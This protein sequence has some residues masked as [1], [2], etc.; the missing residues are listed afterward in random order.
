MHLKRLYDLLNRLSSKVGGPRRLAD[1]DSRT[2]WPQR[3]VYFF[4]EP[5][6]MRPSG[7]PR[8]VR[9]GTHAVSA[10]SQST[11][12]G[13]LKQHRGNGK[14]GEAPGTGN[15]R[16]SIFRRHVGTAL[17]RAGR[18]PPLSSWGDGSSASHEVTVLE[19][20]LEQAVSTYVGQMPFLWLDAD[21]EPSAQSVRGY[22][23]RNSIGLL[24]HAVSIEPPS[25]GW[26]GRHAADERIRKSGLWNVNFV[27]DAYDPGFLD[28]FERLVE[29]TWSAPARA[30]VSP[31]QPNHA[32]AG[33][34]QELADL[35]PPVLALISC[36]KKKATMPCAASELYR[37]STFFRLAFETA[38]RV[39]K[40]TRILSA[41]QGLVRPDEVVA[42]YEQSLVGA[43]RDERRRWA[44]RVYPQLR[45]C[46]EYL[47]AKTVVWFAGESY[48][49][50][51]LPM[52]EADGKRCVV[53]MEGLAQGEQLHWLSTGDA[54]THPRQSLPSRAPALP[55][56]AA[57]NAAPS[58]TPNTQDFRL[59]LQEIKDKAA[60]E[61]RSS[62]V[63]T[64]GALHRIVGGYPG[65]HHRMPMCCQAMRA[66]MQRG[67]AIVAQPPKGNG[68]SLEIA[69]SLSPRS[70][71][72]NGPA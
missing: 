67:D 44:E 72:V 38:G 14:P 53:P 26:L 36:T 9:V 4:F 60:N 16:G 51:L 31:V 8:V 6:E 45:A 20:P 10:G 58:T 29:G 23:E 64:A 30:T 42:P 17:L 49:M 59:A 11:L 40:T 47:A 39:A 33:V 21:D 50:D 57:S 48:R 34:P 5:G 15:H 54:P 52:V 61:G 22:I 1:C 63:V 25:A 55:R 37:P 18:H 69:Y 7:S 24:S 68:A 71:G 66:A 41:K 35:K 28:V 43:S 65:P 3:G 32:G 12:W 13:R 56:A 70:R 27:G 19:E 46:P 62:V 2:G